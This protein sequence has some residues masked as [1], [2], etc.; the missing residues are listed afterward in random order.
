MTTDNPS[1]PDGPLKPLTARVALTA[2]GSERRPGVTGA[3]RPPAVLVI[4]RPDR[5]HRSVPPGG[6]RRATYARN[7][8]AETLAARYGEEARQDMAAEAAAQDLGAEVLDPE[9]RRKLIGTPQ[10]RPEERPEEALAREK[11]VQEK[12][13]RFF[14]L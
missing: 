12:K 2:D 7:I 9:A 6:K 1:R 4:N 8:V 10:G 11:K 13:K 5:A 3:K 14:G